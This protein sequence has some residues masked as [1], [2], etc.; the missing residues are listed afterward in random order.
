MTPYTEFDK[1]R[2]IQQQLDEARTEIKFLRRELELC[3]EMTTKQSQ[4]L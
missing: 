4:K 2:A 1:V 3:Q